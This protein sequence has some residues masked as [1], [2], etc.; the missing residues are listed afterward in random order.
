MRWVTCMRPV[1]RVM[2]WCVHWVG[3]QWWR[4][5]WHS[6][7]LAGAESAETLVS[8]QSSIWRRCYY[9]KESPCWQLRLNFGN[10]LR[11]KEHCVWHHQ[12]QR[13][14]TDLIWTHRCRLKSRL[15]L[16]VCPEKRSANK[17]FQAKSVKKSLISKQH[18]IIPLV[19]PMA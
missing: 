5:R 18:V 17:H 4:V 16:N 12:Y 19:I 8:T 11:S 7:P 14:V 3:R 13:P 10:C 2:K 6:V 15:H 1:R 9:S